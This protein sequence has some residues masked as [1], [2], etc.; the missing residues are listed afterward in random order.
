MNKLWDWLFPKYTLRWE[1]VY[2]GMLLRGS[3]IYDSKKVAKDIA[4]KMNSDYGY[5]RHSH[6][7]EDKNGKRV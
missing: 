7:V 6:W 3:L 1:T 2:R 5:D 4:E